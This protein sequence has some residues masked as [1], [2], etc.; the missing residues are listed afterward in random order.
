MNMKHIV[1]MYL[2]VQHDYLLLVLYF[3]FSAV[4][5]RTKHLKTAYKYSI[6]I[7][8]SKKCW[9][10]HFVE[11]SYATKDHTAQHSSIYFNSL[12]KFP[13]FL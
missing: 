5:T 2:S 4:P 6:F 8:G 9:H 7:L 10:F 1:S 12:F 3:D 13:F 11:R